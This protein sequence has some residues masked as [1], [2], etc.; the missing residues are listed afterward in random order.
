MTFKKILPSLFFF[1]FYISLHGQ[2]VLKGLVKDASTLEPLAFA[3][4]QYS[5]DQGVITNEH[6]GF[7]IPLS[8]EI[9]FIKV[10]FIGYE[11]TSLPFKRSEKPL[12]ILLQ[13]NVNPI[14]E[15]VVNAKDLRASELFFKSIK[16]SRRHANLRQE[17]KL[18]RRTYTYRSGLPAEHMEAF[19][20]A[21]TRDGGVD[22]FH[23]KNGRYGVPND[24][25]FIN[26]QNTNLLQMHKLFTNEFTE[27]PASPLEYTNL[28]RLRKDFD[29]RIR[30]KFTVEQD[31]IIEISFEPL[32]KKDILYQGKV[33]IRNSN[34]IIEKVLLDIEDTSRNPFII[35]PNSDTDKAKKLSMSFNI[36]F[37]YHEDKAVF[38]Y[39]HLTYKTDVETP[40]RSYDVV[41]NNDFFFYDYDD[42]F[43]IPFFSEFSD[44]HYHDYE[45]ILFF[46]Y[47]QEFWKR[48]FLISET[49]EVRQFREELE[50]KQLFKN[51]SGD[52]SEL[53]ERRFETWHPKWEI[54]PGLVA[55]RKPLKG[56]LDLDEVVYVNRPKVP[57]FNYLFAETFIFL[58]Y[59]CYG[60]TVIFNT[61]AV[62]DYRFSYTSYREKNDFKYLE[63]FLHL[64]KIHANE[65]KLKLIK[66]YAHKKDCPG[67][68][69]LKKIL[70]E[71]NNNLQKEAKNFVIKAHNYRTDSK[72]AKLSKEINERLEKSFEGLK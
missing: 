44:D 2:Y 8:E 16:K 53:I 42:P 7:V 12:E 61:E 28:K 17:S 68:K 34:F 15:I 30:N 19:Y 62:L 65:L 22:F 5:E 66:R 11:T 54:I 14:V 43:Q 18:F 60:D 1:F 41:C 26:I 33:W 39:V 45:K 32:R 27:L 24:V 63:K 37:K 57:A 13:Q 72:M 47:D 31:T 67:R 38:D 21:K 59:E 64:T 46:P 40:E 48:N 6:G 50:A 3:T 55:D 56:R 4:V 49:D 36:G 23:L 71:A 9:K 35:I 70:D 51:Q 29:V 25:S 58:D 52:Q 20:T 69:G 10:S